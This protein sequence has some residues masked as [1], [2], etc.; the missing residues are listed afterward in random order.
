[1]S[2]SENSEH[3]ILTYVKVSKRIEKLTEH[4][5]SLVVKRDSPVSKALDSLVSCPF[6]SFTLDYINGDSKFGGPNS[7]SFGTLGS[8][9][10]DA[11][12]AQSQPI[13]KGDPAYRDSR[14][15][16]GDDIT[17]PSD[18]DYTASLYFLLLDLKTVLEATLFVGQE[19]DVFA[20][21][22]YTTRADTLIDTA[23]RPMGGAT[24]R[25]S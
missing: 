17:C 24:T 22:H 3:A 21:S 15:I 12:R 16:L 7:T 13:G 25:P 8:P 20:S 14:E 6:V 11:I 23:T 9:N 5:K 1:M 4:H 19:V 2:A 10:I 18:S